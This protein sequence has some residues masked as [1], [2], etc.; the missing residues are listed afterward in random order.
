[1]RLVYYFDQQS[2]TLDLFGQRQV[3]NRRLGRQPQPRQQVGQP[4]PKRRGAV[5][6]RHM[7]HTRYAHA[8][9]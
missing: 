9:A 5:E 6:A 7:R 1:M 8:L 2:I 3:S 4:G